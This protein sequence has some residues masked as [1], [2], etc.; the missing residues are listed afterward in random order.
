LDFLRSLPFGAQKKIAVLDELRDLHSTKRDALLTYLKEPSPRTI[1]II[2]TA[3]ERL[4]QD[5]FYAD[6]NRYSKAIK[7][8]LPSRRGLP[9]WIEHQFGL[10]KKKIHPDA[11]RLISENLGT[12]L[13]TISEAIELLC[14]YLGQ[15]GR[16]IEVTD[17]QR[18]IGKT[19]ETDAFDL[20]NA[21]CQGETPRALEAL[22]YITGLEQKAT[23]VLGAI[24][25]Q[26]NRLRQA[27]QMLSLGHA[28]REI[29]QTLKIGQS[30]Q[31]R[32]FQQLGK[33]TAQKLQ[34]GFALILEA[35][36]GIKTGRI[37]PVLALELLTIKLCQRER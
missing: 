34:E 12:D 10:R 9:R 15:S 29:A 24:F 2:T 20:V 7:F 4:P 32:F 37:K 11:A 36:R 21:I 3:Q 30:H 22:A 26:W 28:H 14:L 18:A 13:R 1:L 19:L 31:E 27:K 8:P 35:D 33:V 16:I 5:R 6:I 25:W 17:V 23:R